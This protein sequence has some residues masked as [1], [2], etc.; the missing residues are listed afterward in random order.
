MAWYWWLLIVIYGVGA[1]GTFAFHGMMSQMVTPALAAL[2]AIM[3]P[4]FL[5]TG[6]PY[7]D[8]LPMD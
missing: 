2:R 8:R 3:W 7:G 1:I 5:I 6:R 4:V